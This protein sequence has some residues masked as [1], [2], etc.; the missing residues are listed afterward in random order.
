MTTPKFYVVARVVSRDGALPTWKQRIESLVNVSATERLGDSYYWGHSLDG[1]T[2]TIIGLEGYV[3]PVGFFI[4]HFETDVFKREVKLIDGAKLLRHE[5]GLDSPDY[6]LHHYDLEG[7]WLKREDDPHKDSKTSHVAVYHFWAT[8]EAKRPE[9]LQKMVAFADALKGTQGANGPVQS[10]AILKEC[11]DFTMATL[12][13]RTK[14]TD[15]YNAFQSSG[16]LPKLLEELKPITQKQ[17]LRRSQAFN[18]HLELKP[19]T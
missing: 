1:D 3:H 14:N 12:W 4:G 19:S 11:R 18:G 8:E 5:Q 15:A 2:D 9:L 16:P 6:D 13:L 7:G 17:Q 10:C